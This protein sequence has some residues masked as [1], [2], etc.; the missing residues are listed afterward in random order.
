MYLPTVPST[1]PRAGQRER[2]RERERE[3]LDF[4][5]PSTTQGHL[6]ENSNLKTVIFEDSK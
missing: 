4:N 6:R 2:E 3:I 5:I 1:L